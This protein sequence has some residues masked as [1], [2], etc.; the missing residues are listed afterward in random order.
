[1]ARQQVDIVIAGGG[2]AGLTAAAAFGSAGFSVVIADPAPPPQ[3]VEDEASDLRATAFLQPSIALFRDAG[4]WD[5]LAPFAV[6]LDAL[7]VIDTT[8]TPPEITA[9][10]TFEPADV[11]QDS[12]G[13]NLPNWITRKVLTETVAAMPGVDMRSGTAIDGMTQRESE[14]I[15]RLSDGT[16]LSAQL[17]IGAD[18]RASTVRRL[19]S[20]PT[21]T[22]RYGQK[23]LAF[24]VTHPLPH[25]NISTE[26]YN[27]GGA[28]TLVPAQDVDGQSASGVV[29]MQDGDVAQ[30][31]MQMAP[32]DLAEV[33]TLRSCHVLGRLTLASP[34][35]LWP[36]ITQTSTKMAAQRVALVAEAAHV[37]PPIGA[38]G[39]NTSLADI[40]VLRDLAHA[41]PDAL[42]TPKMLDAYEKARGRD[43]RLRASAIDLFNRVCKSDAPLVQGLRTAGLK[44]V[45]DLPGLRR[46][47]MSQGMGVAQNT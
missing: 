6:P 26:I 35:R 43:V 18:G 19:A 32:E 9:E 16:S 20:I 34:R 14:A 31:C 36:V 33:M 21:R 39:L 47:I 38:Q 45:H 30:D 8:G 42:G 1:M 25:N 22:Q 13:W 29:W 10:R 46:T 7:R 12:F 4:V 27:R 11:G 17:L 15:V 23:A 3:A 40:R 37:L 44:T 2:V 41:T 5:E 24:T 28:F